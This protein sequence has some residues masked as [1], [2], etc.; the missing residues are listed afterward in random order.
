M[1]DLKSL[2]IFC[3]L[4]RLVP[5]GRRLSS[6]SRVLSNNALS[7]TVNQTTFCLLAVVEVNKYFFTVMKRTHAIGKRTYQ[8]ETV[9]RNG[10]S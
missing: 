2:Y 5:L 10:I 6:A 8:E 4:L 9:Y 3:Q 1:K 7:F